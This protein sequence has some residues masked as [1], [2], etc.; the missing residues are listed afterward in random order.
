MQSSLLYARR[1]LIVGITALALAGVL[2][3]VLVIARTP[4]LAA[5]T[6]FKDLFGKSL[7][8]HVDLSV[9]VWFLAAAA[10]LWQL[11]EHVQ[12]RSWICLRYVRASGLWCFLIGTVLMAA[13]IVMGG[14]ALKNNYIPM[15][16]NAGF[17]FSL[18]LI[19]AGICLAALDALGRTTLSDFK[20]PEGAIGF[21]IASSAVIV[22]IACLCFYLSAENIRGRVQGEQLYEIIFWGG[23]HVLQFL[24]VQIIMVAWLWLTRALGGGLPRNIWLF[25]LFAIGPLIALSSPAAYLLYDV[26]SFEYRQ[27]FTEQMKWGLGIAP[28]LLG[29]ALLLKLLHVKTP[30]RS[31]R[32]ALFSTLFMSLALFFFGGTF[33]LAIEAET[34]LVPAHYHGSIVGV[35]LALMGA[36]Y[37]LLPRFGGAPVAQS[38]LAFWQ[39]VLYGGGQLMHISG[40]AWSGGYEVLRKTP[41]DVTDAARAAMGMMGL[42]GLLAIIGGII[43]VIV[44]W[45]SLRAQP[46]VA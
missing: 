39:P 45:R 33:G 18:G 40:L 22:L 31:E 14:E 37:L 19:L 10:M 2:A 9:L 46:E 8:I 44:V 26:T 20:A 34:V 27:F 24:Y 28:T 16:T 41:G 30:W 42:G 36:T 21:G 29:C 23:G 6:L 17:V 3:I 4:Q 11:M 15:L 25:P 32:R 12:E 43:F 5:L 13:S 35:T 7:V 1:W 38:R